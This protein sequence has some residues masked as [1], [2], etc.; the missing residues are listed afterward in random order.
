MSSLFEKYSNLETSL[1][2]MRAD[3]E[4]SESEDEE[5]TATLES[6]WWKLKPEEQNL[7]K[8]RKK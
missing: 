5:I 2:R 8:T 3:K 7:L 6:W 4:L 1:L